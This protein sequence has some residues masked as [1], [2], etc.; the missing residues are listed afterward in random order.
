MAIRLARPIRGSDGMRKLAD[1]AFSR[2]ASGEFL[3]RARGR[4]DHA[5][6]TIAVSSNFW[7][8][9][10]EFRLAE[11]VLGDAQKV[12]GDTV[13]CV[14][15]FPLLLELCAAGSGIALLPCFLCRDRDDLVSVDSEVT[16]AELWLVMRREHA[17]PQRIQQVID[18]VVETF[19]SAGL[20][21][22]G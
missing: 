19:T 7:H 10:H 20:S 14:D 11:T 6:N 22:A 1:V 9:D 2:Y 5:A 12:T 16:M 13:A 17:R 4:G 21:L 18:F 8:R 3:R 15:S